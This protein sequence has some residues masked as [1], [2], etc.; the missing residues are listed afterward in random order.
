MSL[1]GSVVIRSFQKFR[2]VSWPKV[3]TIIADNPFVANGIIYGGLYTLAEIS[4]QTIKNAVSKDTATAA[5]ISRARDTTSVASKLDMSSIKRYAIMG[6][7][8]ISPM[9]TKWYSWLDGR[10]PCKTAPVVVK[11]LVLDQFLFTPFVVVV[12]YVGMSYL[13]GKKGLQLLDELKEKGIKTFMMDCCF[14]L[15][16]SVSK[17]V[18]I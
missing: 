12:F 14:W 18:N 16:A 5:N 3:K 6:T 13:E 1:T 4:Q 7:V 8:C 11:K 17:K 2:K 15:P 10:F 9:L